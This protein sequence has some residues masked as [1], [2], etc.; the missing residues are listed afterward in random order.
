M[1]NLVFSVSIA[2]ALLS[3]SCASN[4]VRKSVTQEVAHI[5]KTTVLTNPQIAD[6]KIEERKI[7]G[8]VEVRKKDYLNPVEDAKALAIRSATLS[9]KC[10]LIAQPNF[11]ITESKEA[12]SVKVVGFAAHYKNFRPMVTGDTSAFVMY[13]KI[14][15]NAPQQNE[16]VKRFDSPTNMTS[17]KPVSIGKKIL[18]GIV[19]G[20]VGLFSIFSMLYVIVDY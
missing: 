14:R 7:E 5:N 20:T 13:Q 11:E 1:K 16:V 6:L 3:T 8:S 4:R 17:K 15:S 2:V 9:G 12:I 10:D 18:G 19:I